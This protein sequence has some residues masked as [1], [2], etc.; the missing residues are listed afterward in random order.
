MPLPPTSITDKAAALRRRKRAV[1][2]AVSPGHEAEER[3]RPAKVRKARGRDTKA[4]LAYQVARSPRVNL[5]SLA[6]SLVLVVSFALLGLFSFKLPSFWEGYLQ[7]L[8]YGVMS[9]PAW[10]QQINAPLYTPVV[11]FAVTAAALLGKPLGLLPI[12]VVAILA[13]LGAPVEGWAGDDWLI[14]S[15]AWGGWLGLLAGSWVAIELCRPWLLANQ[16]T[17]GWLLRGALLAFAVVLLI[18]GIKLL[19]LLGQ[20]LWSG[21]GNLE[22]AMQWMRPLWGQATFADFALIYLG[23]LCVRVLRAALWL[24]LY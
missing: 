4:T 1:G 17:L 18:K 21:S 7:A 12:I 14:G 8:N 24:F 13:L 23:L 9:L 3:L 15:P 22:V 6:L 5:A 19:F 11:P 10:Y 16:K 2:K 20:G